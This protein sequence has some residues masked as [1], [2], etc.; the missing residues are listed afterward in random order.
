VDIVQAVIAIGGQASRL[1]RDGVYVAISKSFI[2]FQGRPLLQW[3]LESMRQAGVTSI[4]LCGDH[5]IQLAEAEFTLDRLGNPFPEVRY[6]RDPGYGVHGLPYQV[7]TRHPEWLDETF[8]FECG[9]SLMTPEHYTVLARKKTRK[10]IVFSGFNPHSSNRR[11]PV[12]LA[13]DRVLSIP[14]KIGPHAIAH[15]IVI[16]RGYAARLPRLSFDIERIIQYYALRLQL[17]YVFSDMPPE[18]DLALEMDSAMQRYAAYIGAST[19]AGR[20]T[21][22]SSS[23]RDAVRAAPIY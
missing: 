5:P 10:N 6:F 2:D 15:P 21:G 8:I 18:F 12:I 14:R 17:A 16:D 11:Q 4:V 7:I 22:L 23:M 13:G 9:H 1:R 19:R 20:H 3:N